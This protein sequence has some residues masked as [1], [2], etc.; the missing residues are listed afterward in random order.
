MKTY[1]LSLFNAKN[2][3]LTI[4][5]MVVSLSLIITS[6]ILGMKNNLSMNLL[7]VSGVFF[8]YLSLLHAWRKAR[9]YFYLLA[10]TS[11]ILILLFLITFIVSNINL[12]AVNPAKIQV[13]SGGLFTIVGLCICLPGMIIGLLGSIIHGQREKNI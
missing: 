13:L 11:G 5:F 4:T 6:L 10:V 2:R 9:Q 8:L 7:F 1:L 12:G 3:I